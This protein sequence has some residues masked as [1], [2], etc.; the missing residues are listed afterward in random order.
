MAFR[1]IDCDEGVVVFVDDFAFEEGHFTFDVFEFFGRDGVEVAV[2]DGDVGSL[3]GFQGAHFVFE[4]EERG[5]PGGVG[6]QGGVDVDCFGDAE[7][8]GSGEGLA[9]DGGPEAVAC[10]V[11]RDVVVGASAPAD[12]VVE[13][14]FEGHGVEDSIGT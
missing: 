9:F 10:C 13:I 6:A 4:K 3:A 12:A 14:G 2:P 8:M 7:G 11:R 5:G 1:G